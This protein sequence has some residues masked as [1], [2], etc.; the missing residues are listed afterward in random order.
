MLTWQRRG[1]D[2]A[3]KMVVRRLCAPA[4]NGGEPGVLLGDGEVVLRVR[5]DAVGS[6]VGSASSCA[7]GND[8]GERRA[9]AV[10]AVVDGDDAL[11]L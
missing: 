11:L 5:R 1:A 2:V 8:E 10:G 7:C 6:M 3:A 4:A 9:A